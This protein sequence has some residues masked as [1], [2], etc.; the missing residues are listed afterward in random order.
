MSQKLGHFYGKQLINYLPR[1]INSA[2]RENQE[3]TLIVEPRKV[4]E[5]LFFL[6]NHTNSQFKCLTEI[7]G[8][9]F[10][11]RGARFE[12]VYCLLSVTFN[13]LIRVKTIVDETTPLES[14][15]RIFS[16]ANWI[17]REVWDLFG[18]FFQGHP[19]LRRI[20]TDYGFEGHPFRKDFPLGGYSEVRYDEL[21][22]RVVVEPV[23][24]S[25]E[26]R[27]FDFESPW[28]NNPLAPAF[29]D[30]DSSKKEEK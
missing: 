11:S 28:E 21:K 29:L 24:F 20:L 30:I 3:L 2:Y 8:V 16:G 9:D 6:K 4:Y 23:E 14:V 19:D 27:S 22:K 26:F 17:E 10:P 12:V 1:A 25:Q 7:C 15:T 13:T 18:V 5:V